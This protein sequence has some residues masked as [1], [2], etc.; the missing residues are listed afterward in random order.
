MVGTAFSRDGTLLYIGTRDGAVE[1]WDIANRK[2]V[3]TLKATGKNAAFVGA[4][5]ALAMSP[6]GDLLAGGGRW[7]TVLG[8]L[9][10][11]T[12]KDVIVE[13]SLRLQFSADGTESAYQF[14]E[15]QMIRG[16]GRRDN[17]CAI[18]RRAGMRVNRVRTR[19][20]PCSGTL[21]VIRSAGLAITRARGNESGERN[22]NVPLDRRRSSVPLLPFFARS[23]CPGTDCR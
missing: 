7:G 10:D 1:A 8:N 21:L 17:G 19:V 20:S 3:F 15:R 12:T 22:E 11:K 14:H 4:V 16:S 18:V 5:E 9:R 13:P 2:L 23:G 6:E